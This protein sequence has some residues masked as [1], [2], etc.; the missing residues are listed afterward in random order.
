MLARFMTPA[1]PDARTFGDVIGA[2]VKT[3]AAKGR[4]VRIYGEMVALLWDSQQVGAAIE[5][6]SM[7]NDLSSEVEF[8]L[9]CA[10][11]TLAVTG[12]GLADA[13]SSVTEL[14][15][16]VV[17]K[18]VPAQLTPRPTPAAGPPSAGAER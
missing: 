18:D 8:T 5:L 14:H 17:A 2:L 16:A 6:E 1:G 9:L 15:T 3:E 11:P 7:W 13:L 12:D 10:Y 4:G